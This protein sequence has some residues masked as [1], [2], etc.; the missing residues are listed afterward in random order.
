MLAAKTGEGARAINRAANAVV[1]QVVDRAIR[2]RGEVGVQVAAYLG[3][4]L[5]I[6]AW[7]GIAD[8]PTRRPVDGDTLFNVASVTKGVAATALHVQAERGVV[9]YDRPVAHYWPE[10]GVGGKDK[11][12]VR[13]A[14]SH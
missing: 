12:T 7:G 14:L 8:P 3:G 5:V 6:D 2:E 1:Q 13:D 11:V 4:E 9:D 10:Y